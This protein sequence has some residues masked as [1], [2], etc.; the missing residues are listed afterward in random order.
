M[1][2][3]RFKSVAFPV[4]QYVDLQAGGHTYIPWLFQDAAFAHSIL[5]VTSASNDFRLHQPLSRPTIFHLKRTLKLLNKQ[6]NN[7]GAYLADTTTYTI[8]TLAVLASMFGDLAATKAHMAGLQ[9]IVQLRGGDRLISE[10]PKQH[11]MLERYVR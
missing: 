5:L 9:R 3:D 10:C 6:L 8:V 11:F 2:Y 7:K 1:V 4:E